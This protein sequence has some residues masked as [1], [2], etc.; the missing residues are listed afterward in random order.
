MDSRQF[1][2]VSASHRLCRICPFLRCSAI[3]DVRKE[4]T[5][6]V[7]LMF[8]YSFLAMAAYNIV[9]PLTRS[10]FIDKL[11][12]DNLPYVLLV[13]GIII[14][15]LMPGYA[16]PWGG[17]R[18]AGRCRSRRRHGRPAA[19]ASGCFSRPAGSG[20]RSRSTCGA[21][22]AC[23]SSAS[24]GRLPTSS[25]TRGRPSACSDS[26]AAAPARRHHRLRLRGRGA[27]RSAP[28]PAAPAAAG[29]LLRALRRRV[30]RRRAKVVPPR[31]VARGEDEKGISPAEAFRLLRQSQHLQVIALVISFAAIGAASSSSRSTWRT[32]PKG[33]RGR[34]RSRRS[35]PSRPLDVGGRLRHPGL[36]DVRLHRFLGIGFA[37]LLMPVSLGTAALIMLFNAA[38]WAPAVARVLDS[39]CATP[40]TR[41]RARS[42]SCRCRRHEIQGEAVCRRHRRPFGQ[43]PRAPFCSLCSQAV[44]PPLHLAAVEL[45]EPRR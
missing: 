7:L 12:A 22:W 34:T 5:V 45:R 18:G 31:V 2:S 11:G 20:C 43:G 36:A 8:A 38:L 21:S 6:T 14:G 13:S 32:P 30:D 19:R 3:V 16:R 33:C 15:F 35:S 39:R 27:R 28:Q 29:T 9:K 10:Q 17:C 4:E 24:S 25:S 37:L 41:R 26:S 23:C 44:G 40:S 42:C 1:T